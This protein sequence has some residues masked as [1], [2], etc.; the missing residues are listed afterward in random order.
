MVK[1]KDEMASIRKILNLGRTTSTGK[2]LTPTPANKYGMYYTGADYN[3]APMTKIYTCEATDGLY[4][5]KET[6]YLMNYRKAGYGLP[7]LLPVINEFEK[8]VIE[9][10][11][12]KE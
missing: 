9:K 10:R 4:Q 2:C 7:M 5:S 6:T 1:L 8:A 3:L 12:N 11:R